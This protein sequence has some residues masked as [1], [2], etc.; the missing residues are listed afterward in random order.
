MTQMRSRA[1]RVFRRIFDEICQA[2]SSGARQCSLR[3]IDSDNANPPLRAAADN[4]NSSTLQQRNTTHRSQ[5]SSV[6]KEL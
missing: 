5:Q 2:A 1:V 3:S 4:F 6:C